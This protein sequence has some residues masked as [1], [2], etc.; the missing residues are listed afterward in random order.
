MTRIRS[1]T[2][3]EAPIILL[4]EIRR[5]MYEAFEGDF[6]Q[7]DWDHT[8][9]GRHVIAEV[10]GV[11]VSHA[12]VIERTIEVAGRAFKTGYVEG[13][14]TSPTRQGRGFGTAVMNEVATVVKNGF[15]LGALGTDSQP[16]Y[17]R[18]GWER[19]RGSSFVRQAS[20]L[21]PTPEEDGSLMV[22]RFG[23]SEHVDLAESI[24]CEARPGDDW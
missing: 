22:L 7:E 9:G 15:E 21:E 8:I 6:A 17:E 14:A 13:V 10:E 18:L 11:L 20:M 5:L 24:S 4:D 2:T 16:F 23:P 19:W 1:F 3:D 12:S